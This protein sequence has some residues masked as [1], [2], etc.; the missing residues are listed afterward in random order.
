MKENVDCLR[1]EKEKK[2]VVVEG[3]FLV[4]GKWIQP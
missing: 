1:K 4:G 2:K 3:Y